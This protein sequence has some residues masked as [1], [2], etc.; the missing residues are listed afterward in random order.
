MRELAGAIDRFPA[1]RRIPGLDWR[2]VLARDAARI[3]AMTPDEWAMSIAGRAKPFYS[4]MPD[5]IWKGRPCFIVGGGPSLVGFNFRRLKGHRMIAINR[6]FEFVPDADILFS[7]DSYYFRESVKRTETDPRRFAGFK[8]WLDMHGYPFCDIYLVQSNGENGLSTSI[9]SGLYHGS[10]SG[11]AAINLAVCLRADPIYLLGFDMNFSGPR[12][13]FHSGYALRTKL[14][15]VKRYIG[16]FNGLAVQL[17][18]RGI[19]VVNLSP[20]SALGC[21]EKKSIDEVLP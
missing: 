13:H 18:E 16:N 17:Q 5:D 20:K 21:F 3:E 10:N 8:V 7:I 6:A 12:S 4:V 9:A 19:K 15:K 11:Y 1:M 2:A 14:E